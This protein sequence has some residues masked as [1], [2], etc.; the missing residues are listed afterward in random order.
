VSRDPS[1]SSRDES[2]YGAT[3]FTGNE[4]ATH[5]PEHST[6]GST[7][8]MKSGVLGAPDQR[9]EERALRSDGIAAQDGAS[10]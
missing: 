1:S 5:R 9:T 3:E 2:G 6:A 4:T 8:S 7:L 10:R